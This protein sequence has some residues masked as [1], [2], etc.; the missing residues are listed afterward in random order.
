MIQV[1]G[2]SIKT[3][4]E[5]NKQ[6]IFSL[7]K[8]CSDYYV[9]VNGIEADSTDIDDILYGLPVGRTYEDK[10]VLG[11][12]NREDKLTALIDILKNYPVQNCWWIGLLLIKVSERGRGLGRI[13][14]NNL[15]DFVIE[16]SGLEIQLGVVEENEKAL[17]F[18]QKLGFE[19]IEKRD[20]AIFRTKEHSVF[21]MQCKLQTGHK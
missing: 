8:N 19:I 1:P 10:I 18:W 2:Y 11:L 16:N 20:P 13:I 12:F 3:L 4:S 6:E 15:K 14:F 9:I 21:V 7:I 17:N 5:E